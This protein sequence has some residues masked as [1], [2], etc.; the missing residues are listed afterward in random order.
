MKIFLIIIMLLNVTADL[1]MASTPKNNFI[2]QNSA[3]AIPFV[4][5]SI[6]TYIEPSD[7]NYQGL[8]DQRENAY[9]NFLR[10]NIDNEQDNRNFNNEIGRD[11]LPFRTLEAN[12]NVVDVINAV[13]GVQTVIPLRWNNPHSAECEINIWIKNAAGS[14][15][16]IPIK[17]PS[18]CGEGYQDQV[19]DFTIPSDFIQLSSKVQGFTGC[20]KIGDCTLQIYGHS[21][22]PRTYAI[23]TP[24]IISNIVMANGTITPQI[25]P[26]TI[27]PQLNLNVLPRDVCLP[28]TD[29]TSNVISNVPKFARLVSDQFNHAYQNSDFSPYSGQQHE[30]ISRNLQSATILR[31][32]AA[33][34]GELGQS[35]L[36][37]ENKKF[38]STLII[39][40][41][42]VVAK[43][44]TVANDIFNTIKDEYATSAKIA[45]QQLANCFRC[46]DTGSVNTQRI[47]QATYIPSFEIKDVNRANEIRNNLDT[48]VKNL[49]PVNSKNVQ[50]YTAALTEMANDF[51]NAATKGFVYQ[52]AML[53]NQIT[54]MDDITNF[55]K[56]DAKGEQDN[57]VYASRVAS[58]IKTQ[59]INK[60][61]S[62]STVTST[63][64]LPTA[65]PTALPSGLPTALPSGLPTTARV[66]LPPNPDDQIS[67]YNFCGLSYETIDCTK[68]CPNGLI[69]ECAIGNCFNVN[70]EKCQSVTTTVIA[71]GQ[72]TAD[73]TTPSIS[74]TN[75][76]LQPST[77]VPINNIYF[78]GSESKTIN[79][80]RPCQYGLDSE[81]GVDTCFY[82]TNCPLPSVTN[83]DPSTQVQVNNVYFCGY[84]INNYNCSQSCTSGLSSECSLDNTIICLN[85]KTACFN[86]NNKSSTGEVVNNSSKYN[87]G[88]ILLFTFV[89]QS[90]IL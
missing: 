29:A 3:G 69:S 51:A 54:T 15:V 74:I 12:T 66:T 81:C 4:K 38:I 13:P 85:V 76:N 79:C 75:T 53:K 87:P 89:L 55:L 6:T 32:T 21:V 58:S 35:I 86:N 28:T 48:D 71:T 59:N 80:N 9:D 23:G 50:I 42:K 20:N 45:N 43:Y 11:M 67:I 44:E 56:V 57:G 90:F 16:V 39:N 63:T 31:M 61:T 25:A 72:P 49:I 18:C 41:N 37:S 46:V 7:F 68:P 83:F 47:E 26:S 17:K 1:R 27:D 65:L 8:K 77:Q 10:S 34:G 70:P 88:I 60:I 62:L 2:L 64:V 78:C 73:P 36:S 24:L 22:E 30:F 33:N 19:I 40:V 5:N 52:P 84:D 14:D 82:T